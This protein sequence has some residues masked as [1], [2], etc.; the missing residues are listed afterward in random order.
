MSASSKKVWSTP[1]RRAF[2]GMVAAAATA[3]AARGK[4]AAIVADAREDEDDPPRA[5]WTGATRWIGH[6]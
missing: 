4:V 2:V 1:T 6:C 3:I 5:T